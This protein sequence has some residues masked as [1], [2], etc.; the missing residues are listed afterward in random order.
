MK[1]PHTCRL[2]AKQSHKKWAA[3]RK[4][5]KSRIDYA[6]KSGALLYMYSIIMG[7]YG[8]HGQKPETEF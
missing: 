1:H 8:E 2:A 5:V 3:E 7:S 6:V 4:C